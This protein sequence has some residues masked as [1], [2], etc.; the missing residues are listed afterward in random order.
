MPTRRYRVASVLL[1]IIALLAL[2][3]SLAPTFLS[4]GQGNH[5]L[6]GAINQ[7]IHGTLSTQQIKLG[8]VSGFNAR[9]IVLKDANGHVIVDAPQV[10]TQLSLLDL[11]RDPKPLGKSNVIVKAM[12]LISYQDGSTNLSQALRQRTATEAGSSAPSLPFTGDVRLRVNKATWTSPDGKS[13]TARD[14]QGQVK[15]DQGLLVASISSQVHAPRLAASQVRADIQGELNLG[16]ATFRAT[17]LSIVEE[18][19]RGRAPSNRIAM[20]EGSVLNFGKGQSDVTLSVQYDLQR[21]NQLLAPLLPRDLRMQGQHRVSMR[22]Q[23]HLTDAPGLLCLRNISLSKTP[24]VFTHFSYKGFVL[25]NGNIPVQLEKGQLSFGNA[26]LDAS[27]GV[28]TLGGHID[29]NGKEP[30]YVV[31]QSTALVSGMAISHELAQG[32]L[33]FLPTSW[34]ASPKSQ[35]DGTVTARVHKASL[36]LSKEG[37][38]ERG[39]LLGQL[40]IHNLDSDSGGLQAIAQSLNP[41]AALSSLG[42]VEVKSQDMTVPFQLEDGRVQ[43]ENL[44]MQA[45]PLNLS[46]SGSVGVDGTID[47]DS[48]VDAAGIG[49]PA[50]IDIGGTVK[51]PEIQ[52]K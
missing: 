21:L 47:A 20:R 28:L 22:V 12:N 15:I 14:T 37:F 51:Q 31:D 49:V 50:K 2:I 33:K 52:L 42:N 6:L 30:V 11:F 17:Q 24:L 35:V 1:G 40:E 39:E 13:I 38:T 4:T 43:F 32:P 18:G 10:T 26:R 41:V 19:P 27:G 36:P 46:F 23:G 3:V 5:V 8:W 9:G 44:R 25:N 48:H 7:R 16:E 34:G 29:L 45:G